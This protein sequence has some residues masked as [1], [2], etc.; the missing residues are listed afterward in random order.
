MSDEEAKV[1]VQETIELVEKEEGDEVGKLW[2]FEKKIW[3]F[4]KTLKN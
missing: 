3:K 4:R 1:E 2:F